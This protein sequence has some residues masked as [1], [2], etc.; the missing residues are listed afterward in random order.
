MQIGNDKNLV[1]ACSTTNT[2][3]YYR[4]RTDAIG[5]LVSIPAKQVNRPRKRVNPA[6]KELEPGPK[7]L[8]TAPSGAFSAR[9]GRS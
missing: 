3:N 6:P 8:H 1:D 9:Q 7:D 4:L 5:R 2:V